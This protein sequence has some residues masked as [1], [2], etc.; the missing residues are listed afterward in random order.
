MPLVGGGLPWGNNMTSAHN[1]GRSALFG[2]DQPMQR[3]TLLKGAAALGVTAATSS[4]LQLLPV[5]ARAAAVLPGELPDVQFDIGAFLPPPVVVNE[6]GAPTGTMFGFGPVYTLFLTAKLRRTPTLTDQRVLDH[7]LGRIEA[8]YPFRP[9]GVFTHIAYGIPYFRR[10]PGGLRGGL[11]ARNM[12]RLLSDPHRYAL[13][14]AVPGPTDVHPTNPAVVKK[15]FNVRMRVESNDVLLTLRSDNVANLRDVA[16]W[17]RGSG[18]L[19][20]RAVMSPAFGRLFAWTSHRLMFGGRGIP[21]RIADANA[22]PYAG[23]IHPDSPMWL[24]FADQVADAFGPPDIVCF[25]GNAKA[26][27]TDATPRD[28][29]ANG[30]IQVLNHNILDLTEWY[31]TNDTET[32][33]FNFDLAYLERVQYMY[34]SNNPPAFGYADQF[35]DGGGPAF[36]PNKFQGFH[37]ALRGAAMGSLQPGPTVDAPVRNP[38]HSILGHIQCLH[39]ASRTA[40]G[41]PLHI[42]VDGPGFSSMDVPDGTSQ[43]KLQF[44]ALVPT[45]QLFRKMRVAQAAPR[46]VQRFNVEPGDQGLETRISATRRQ[47]FLMPPR[48]HRVFPL[49]ELA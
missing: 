16:L 46:L 32:D 17:L 39:Q 8:T 20:G 34:R 48:S 3:R 27:L 23:R 12:P 31:L 18:R 43:P 45:A 25:Q 2:A 37:D 14:E 11:V 24:G 49:L 5:P 1:N 41:T 19:K 38:S 9:S 6:P 47:N 21:R 10:L 29:F 40:D 22:L 42:R 4:A 7:A 15:R 35:T 13:E 28:Y 30:S 26:K 33:P 36:L 44:S